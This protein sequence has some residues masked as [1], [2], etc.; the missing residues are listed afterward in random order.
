MA[1]EWL[2]HVPD[3]GTRRMGIQQWCVDEHLTARPDVVRVCA[4]MNWVGV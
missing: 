3:P 1:W 2:G 4:F